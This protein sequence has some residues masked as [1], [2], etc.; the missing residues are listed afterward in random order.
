MAMIWSRVQHLP[1]L[2]WLG[3]LVLM[4]GYFYFYRALVAANLSLRLQQSLLVAGLLLSI[5]L[6]LRF[7][8]LGGVAA[9][10]QPASEP[11]ASLLSAWPTG[12]LL[13]VTWAR[14]V[15]LANRSLSAESIGFSFRAGILILAAAVVFV[16]FLTTRDTSVFVIFYF[17]FALVAVALARVEQV[18]HSPSS[19]RGQFSRYWIG[20]AIGAV[21]GL[22]TL[23]LGLVA[24]LQIGGLTRV[25][26]LLSPLLRALQW[27]VVGL[28]VLLLL[29]LEWVLGLF[30]WNLDDLSRS[31]REAFER[32]DYL[33]AA[34]L[35]QSL[36]TE[37]PVMNPVVQAILQGALTIGLPTLI[38]VVVLVL[39]WRRL[40]RVR[41][42]EQED[43]AR[44]SLLSA[45]LL[46]HSLQSAIQD[47][48]DR[49]SALASAVGRFGPATRFFTALTV[50]RIYANLV[51]LA[52]EAGYP[53][54][55]AQTPYEYLATLAEAFPDSAE[56]VA[57]IT[58]AYVGAHYGQLPDSR[59]EL[60]RI[61]ACWER[62]RA[63]S[64]RQK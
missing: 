12:M 21:G 15:H 36:P 25:L 52:T 46:A 53:R 23:G 24:F 19:A 62:V 35:P 38:I 45:R 39:S 41:L 61:R 42:G 64:A 48:L 13:V 26:R 2:L 49:L 57:A 30:A 17:F 14:A 63:Q 16:R 11:A 51:R 3:M 27:I 6:V 10:P 55:K 60:E 54:P 4:L 59:Q 20:A 32:L 1:F 34:P 56:E 37:E 28:G 58:E 44:E 50:R 9:P 31:L 47:G 7:H 22:I 18:S 40:R 29:V 5:A 8:A 33:L 43:E